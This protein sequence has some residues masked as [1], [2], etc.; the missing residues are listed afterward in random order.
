MTSLCSLDQR[1]LPRD[2]R[3]FVA[4]NAAVS[5]VTALLGLLFGLSVASTVC[6]LMLA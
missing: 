6:G 5:P 1:Q 4:E 2:V 3:D